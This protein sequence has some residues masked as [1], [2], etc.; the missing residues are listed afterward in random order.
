MGDPKRAVFFFRKA[1]SINPEFVSAQNNLNNTLFAL[2]KRKG[3]TAA[4]Q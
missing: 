2:E 3:K 4:G 1:L